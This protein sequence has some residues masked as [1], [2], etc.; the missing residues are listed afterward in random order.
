MTEAGQD[1]E[2]GSA[3][4]LAGV[5]KLMDSLDE[6]SKEKIPGLKAQWTGWIDAAA[7]GNPPKAAEMKQ[8]LLAELQKLADGSNVHW[9]VYA[10]NAIAAINKVSDAADTHATKLDAATLKAEQSV[11]QNLGQLADAS[12]APIVKWSDLIVKTTDLAEQAGTAHM[13]GLHD[14]LLA[15]A[16]QMASDTPPPLAVVQ[17]TISDAL[18]GAAASGDKSL[19][20]LVQGEK[21]RLSQMV[22][23]AQAKG[24]ELHRALVD[25]LQKSM[26]P[27]PPKICSTWLRRPPP[28]A[29]PKSRRAS[30]ISPARSPAATRRPMAQPTSN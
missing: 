26:S 2:K 23:D 3:G 29:R 6:V 4:V 11:V 22:Q 24:R 15:L 19:Q 8:G 17:Q 16:T 7:K 13:T 21:D 20:L 12:Q 25:P 10:R 14:K 9:A 30:P 18:A 1:T 27:K 5:Q 28:P